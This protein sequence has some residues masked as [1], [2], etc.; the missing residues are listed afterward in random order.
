MNTSE[1][2]L[3][4]SDGRHATWLELFSGLHTCASCT[5]KSTA[6]LLFNLSFSQF[7]SYLYWCSV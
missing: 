5:Q 3:Y 1:N 2:T 4:K 7:T 6:I